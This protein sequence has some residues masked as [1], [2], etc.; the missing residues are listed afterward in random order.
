MR[1]LSGCV[2]A[3]VG[4]PRMHGTLPIGS[5]ERSWEP[6]PRTPLHGDPMNRRLPDAFRCSKAVALVA[7]WAIGSAL[8]AAA[9]S[10]LGAAPCSI[11]AQ[12]LPEV[13]ACWPEGARARLVMAVAEKFECDVARLRQ[14]RTEIDRATTTSCPREREAMLGVLKGKS[15]AEAL[16]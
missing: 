2:A 4:V 15:I 12:L 9:Q 14:V 8:P 1:R 7:S 10:A 13:R 11:L 16:S 3:D 5:N 6:N